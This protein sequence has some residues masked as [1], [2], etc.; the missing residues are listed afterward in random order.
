[1][2]STTD[3]NITLC[4]RYVY[5]SGIFLT[6]LTQAKWD[7]FIHFSVEQSLQY[8]IKSNLSL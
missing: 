4:K 8:I 5:L 1:M 3:Y 6:H 7:D 2:S